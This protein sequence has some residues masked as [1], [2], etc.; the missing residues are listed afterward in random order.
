MTRATVIWFLNQ[1]IWLSG[2][3]ALALLWWYARRS[4]RDRQA[5]LNVVTAQRDGALNRN[6]LLTDQ[7]VGLS[8]AILAHPVSRKPLPPSHPQRR[9]T[10]KG[11]KP[12]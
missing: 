11:R 12:R 10:R 6:A 9:Q 4:K 1:A 5:T 8:R 2:P 3:L 7:V